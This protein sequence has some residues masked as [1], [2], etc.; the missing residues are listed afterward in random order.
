MLCRAPQFGVCHPYST[1]SV[2]FITIQ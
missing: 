2:P 1:T